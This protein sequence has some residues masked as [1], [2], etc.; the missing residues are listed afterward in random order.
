MS[1]TNVTTADFTHLN[2]NQGLMGGV[3]IKNSFETGIQ[4]PDS[5]Q[6]DTKKDKSKTKVISWVTSSTNKVE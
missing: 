3:G 2:F 1:S 5:N 6:L 4:S